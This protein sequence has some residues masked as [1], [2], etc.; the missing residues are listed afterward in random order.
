MQEDINEEYLPAVSTWG[1]RGKSLDTGSSVA[2]QNNQATEKEQ[3]AFITFET[4]CSL[5][6]P[7]F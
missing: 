2:C 3:I 7:N 5:Y 6:N 1:K 4:I